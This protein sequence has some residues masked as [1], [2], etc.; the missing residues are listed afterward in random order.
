MENNKGIERLG[1]ISQCNYS[2]FWLPIVTIAIKNYARICAMIP[3]KAV[4]NSD[5]SG[6]QRTAY[7]KNILKK[8]QKP[9]SVQR[10]CWYSW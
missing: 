8:Q 7:T 3:W 4:S 5:S 6:S 10:T 9:T 2:K 1:Y